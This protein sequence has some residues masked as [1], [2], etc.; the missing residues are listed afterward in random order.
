METAKKGEG[1]RGLRPPDWHPEPDARV[2]GSVRHV[3][4]DPR[5]LGPSGGPGSAFRLISDWLLFLGVLVSPC[6]DCVVRHTVCP[7]GDI[8]AQLRNSSGCAHGSVDRF[9][10]L[11]GQHVVA[12]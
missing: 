3:G 1:L 6:S 2:L 5:A 11:R 9:C 10:R 8:E 7:Q 12:P 4:P